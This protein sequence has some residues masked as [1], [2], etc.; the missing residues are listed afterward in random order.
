MSARCIEVMF[1]VRSATFQ[2]VIPIDYD[3]TN[4]TKLYKI[5]MQVNVFN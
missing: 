3:K 4:N 1:S 2:L 5:L